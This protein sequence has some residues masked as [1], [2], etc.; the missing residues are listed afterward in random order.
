MNNP[1]LLS[2]KLFGVAA[3]LVMGCYIAALIAAYFLTK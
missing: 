3:M 1:H 2:A